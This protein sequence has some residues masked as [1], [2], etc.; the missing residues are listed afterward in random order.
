MCDSPRPAIQ[1]HIAVTTD[2]IFCGELPKRW[3]SRVPRGYG[4]KGEGVK[5]SISDT[6]R[7]SVSR[8]P[9]LKLVLGERRVCR[10][11]HGWHAIAYAKVELGHVLA[12]SRSTGQPR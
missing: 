5:C 4:L 2:T 11:V 10:G 7:A 1:R 12:Y 9:M 6:N 8:A 3:H